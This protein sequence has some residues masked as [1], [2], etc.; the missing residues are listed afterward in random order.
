MGAWAGT[1]RLVRLSLC[2][3]ELTLLEA[4]IVWCTRGLMTGELECELARIQ[5]GLIPIHSL[6][7]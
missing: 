1:H 6:D 3:E 7:F 2:A 5:H 4:A